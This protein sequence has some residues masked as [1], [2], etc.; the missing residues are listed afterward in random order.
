M[1]LTDLPP[2]LIV[3]DYW[4]AK[5]PAIIRAGGDILRGER[6]RL[7]FAGVLPGI[8]G[9]LG[10]GGVEPPVFINA[11]HAITSGTPTPALPSGWAAGDLL[12]LWQ[13]SVQAS[14]PPTPT[15]KSGF[16]NIRT[17]VPIGSHAGARLSYK[18]AQ[19]GETAP[20]LSDHGSTNAAYLIAIRG[21]DASPID[22][23]NGNVQGTATTSVSV[24]G[25]TTTQDND[26]IVIIA[27]T[28][29]GDTGTTS[30]AGW[31]N[32]DL[33]GITERDDRTQDYYQAAIVTA[34]KQTAGAT[35]TTT[36]TS[37]ASGQHGNLIV[38][39]KG[40]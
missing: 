31:A 20:T 23:S 21:V 2:Q 37:A 17:Q 26:L 14:S 18:I 7:R 12:L 11:T 1:A 27:T 9:V 40:A 30:I 19:S 16:T 32:A 8:G 10:G 25:V 24:S 34:V 36:A 29:T 5:K 13:Y 33:T 28:L 39:I 38:A 6:E 4:E 35:G 15:L 22:V 3:P